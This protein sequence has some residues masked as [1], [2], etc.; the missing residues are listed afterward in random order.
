MDLSSVPNGWYIGGSLLI[1]VAS[2]VFAILKRRE[3]L[4]GQ[5]IESARRAF[6]TP[7][8]VDAAVERILSSFG[9]PTALADWAGDILASVITKVPDFFN[10]SDAHLKSVASS[11]FGRLTPNAAVRIVPVM[12]K[13]IAGVGFARERFAAGLLEQIDVKAVIRKA[14][15]SK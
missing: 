10:A 8:R 7:E 11:A 2:A 5:I 14:G 6:I 3:T 1:A 9:V 4:L 15:I 12:P 13:D